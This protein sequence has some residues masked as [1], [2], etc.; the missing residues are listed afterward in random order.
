MIGCLGQRI[1][2]RFYEQIVE[3]A[4]D[5]CP[6][7][8]DAYGI[9]AIKERVMNTLPNQFLRYKECCSKNASNSGIIVRLK[10]NIWKV[11]PLR[12]L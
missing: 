10:E 9:A 1:N 11:T 3:N 2:I 4:G 7:L 5:T 6:V 12:K 8:S